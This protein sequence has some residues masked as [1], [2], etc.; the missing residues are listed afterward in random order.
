MSE[1]I[2]ITGC[3]SGIGLAL[4]QVL[5]N[6]GQFVIATA[7]RLEDLASLEVGLKVQLD[8]TDAASI[9]AAIDAAGTIDVLVNNAGYSLWGPVEAA[10]DDDIA[11]IFNTNVFGAL[12][13]CRAVLPG[14]R[15]R[16]AG[17][18]FQISSAAGQRSTAV[19]GHYAASKA[20][21]DAY[22]QALRI[23]L[24]PFGISVCTVL[25]GAVESE[26]PTNRRIVSLEPYEAIVAASI[27]RVARSRTAP[28]SAESVAL[29]IADAILSGDPPLRLDGS[30]D[31]FALVAQRTD[32]DDAAWEEETLQ[33]LFGRSWNAG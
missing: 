13:M 26:F 20:A 4:A 18:I 1:R 8:V 23:E 31:A 11:G 2:L 30:G 17:S 14:M 12:R 24:C 28:H 6:R 7:R 32:L 3:S 5:S 19:L 15:A 25:L 29:R 33:G 10:S 21:L 9:A 22:S 27:D 16:K